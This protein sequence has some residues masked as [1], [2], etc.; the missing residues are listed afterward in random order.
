MNAVGK[1]NF[2]PTSQRTVAGACQHPSRSCILTGKNQTRTP[3]SSKKAAD[4]TLAGT[5]PFSEIVGLLFEASVEYYHVD[6]VGLRKTFY[7][8]TGAGRWVMTI[9]TITRTCGWIRCGRWPVSRLIRW[10]GTG[11]QADPLRRVCWKWGMRCL[12]K[13]AQEIVVNLEAM[14]H[15]VHGIQEGR[16]FNADYGD[17]CYLPLYAFAG[18]I[19]LWAQ[20]RTGDQDAAAGGGGGAGKDRGGDSETLPAGA[21]HGGRGQRFLPG[22]N[23][24]LVR[25]AKPDGLLRPGFGEKLRAGGA[26]EA[27]AGRN[28]TGAGDGGQCPGQVVESGRPKVRVR[29]RRGHV[30]LSRA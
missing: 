5:M 21:D 2:Y 27:G 22:G 29:V 28:G 13:Q 7:R 9:T 26:L 4:A 3:N 20:W 17:Y 18:D 16:H 8:A 11:F 14:G 19:P 6:Y 12:P 15:W 23:S 30:P 10:A 25:A 24:G 1:N